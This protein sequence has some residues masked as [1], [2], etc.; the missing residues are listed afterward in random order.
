MN[1]I[2]TQEPRLRNNRVFI[3]LLKLR[4]S[5]LILK[6]QSRK[7]I[8]IFRVGH[9]TTNTCHQTS[10]TNAR[11]SCH[12]ANLTSW[13]SPSVIVRRISVQFINLSQSTCYTTNRVGFNIIKTYNFAFSYNIINYYLFCLSLRVFTF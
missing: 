10:F 1:Q 3:Q 4:K 2:T 11:T 13:H 5:K 12:Q 6:I 8:L 9:M 7:S